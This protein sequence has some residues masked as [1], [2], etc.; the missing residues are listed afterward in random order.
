M[1]T[2]R[3]VTGVVLMCLFAA[4]APAQQT[5]AAPGAQ[6][7]GAAPRV[8]KVGAVKSINGRTVVLKLDSGPDLTVTLSEDARLLRLQPGQTDL[9]KAE[10]VT[11]SEVQVGDRM[12][13]RCRQ[14]ET[15][16]SLLAFTAVLMKQS[17][18]AQKQQKDLQDWQRRGAGGIVSAVDKATGTITVSST[19]TSSISIKTS[20]STSFLRYA[21]NSVKFAD[22]QKSSFE[23]IKVG[24][25]LRARGI[26]S[27]DGKEITAEEVI[28]GTFRNIAGTVTNVNAADG[29][30]TV[31]DVLASKTVTVKVTPDS[32]M[33]KLPAQLAQR[34]AFFLKSPEP[35]QTGG[36]ASAGAGGSGYGGNRNAGPGGPPGGGGADFQQMINRLPAITTADLQKEEAVM[37]VSTPGTG[38]SEVMAITVLSGVE[39]IL[40]A[41]PNASG[42]A[43]L[44]NGW[45]LSGP[46]GEG[47]GQ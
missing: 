31:K 12:L 40:T 2:T 3:M 1:N 6:Q 7:P 9:K 14:G 46:P 17:D 23:E 32:Q 5:E 22:A 44:L 19:P 45:N 24:D 16:D 33:R 29:T 38:G 13:V 47:G 4:H 8:S 25:Q 18:V 39:P 37:I 28:S 20:P 30:I 26:R 34:I 15:P 10:A 43:A 41:S 42:A 36:A 11:L 27:A 35:A 21:P